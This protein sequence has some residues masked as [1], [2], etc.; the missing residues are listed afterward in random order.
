MRSCCLTPGPTARSRS[1]TRSS[2]APAAK[3]GPVPLVNLHF[4]FIRQDRSNSCRS[5]KSP[6]L[7]ARYGSAQTAGPYP[8]IMPEAVAFKLL[9]TSGL[10]WPLRRISTVRR[11]PTHPTSKTAEMSYGTVA[12]RALPLGESPPAIGRPLG[13][14]RVETTA[15]YARMV[16]DSVRQAAIRNWESIAD[17]TCMEMSGLLARSG[18]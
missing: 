3:T 5:A 15:R 12:S 18:P 6:S 9:T 16:D 4:I 17:D 10:P 8:V 14:C 2:S 13:H 1:S 7:S 11:R